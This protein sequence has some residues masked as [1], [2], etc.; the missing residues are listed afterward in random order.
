MWTEFGLKQPNIEADG[1]KLALR[2]LN[3]GLFLVTFSGSNLIASITITPK[4]LIHG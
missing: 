3:L 2:E 1:A 4:D